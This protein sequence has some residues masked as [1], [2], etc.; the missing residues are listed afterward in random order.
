AAAQ[1][2]PG[3]SVEF[4]LKCVGYNLEKSTVLFENETQ[5][6]KEYPFT[7][8]IAADGVHSAVRHQMQR[9]YGFNYSQFYSRHVNK[10]LSIPAEHAKKYELKKNH[11]HIWP[12]NEFMI[13]AFPNRDGSLTCTLQLPFED[14]DISFKNL[15]S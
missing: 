10:E 6:Q 7:T 13:I 4:G 12:R 14:D 1:Q 5:K 8:L 3:I 9:N 2:T 11:L 15:N